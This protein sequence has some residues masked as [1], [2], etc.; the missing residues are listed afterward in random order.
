MVRSGNVITV[1]FPFFSLRQSYNCDSERIEIYENSISYAN[2]HA[3]LCG[4][5]PKTYDSSSNMLQIV[6]TSRE[7]PSKQTFFGEYYVTEKR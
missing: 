2:R 3:R 1:K 4:N 7:V 6:Y 5:G